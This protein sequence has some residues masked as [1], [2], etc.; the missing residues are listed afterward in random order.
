M[1]LIVMLL[2]IPK[3]V[4]LRVLLLIPKV[5][6]KVLLLIPKVIFRVIWCARA[7]QLPVRQSAAAVGR[8]LGDHPRFTDANAHPLSRIAARLGVEAGGVGWVPSV[9][10]E[11]CK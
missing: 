9:E 6:F 3:V 8:R 4:T 5:I 1:F 2:L 10:S 7:V 11:R